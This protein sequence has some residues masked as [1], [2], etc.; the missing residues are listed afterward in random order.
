MMRLFVR[1]RSTKSFGPDDPVV[2][3][4]TPDV[5]MVEWEKV[6]VVAQKTHRRLMAGIVDEKL[7]WTTASSARDIELVRA[8]CGES[9]A[10]P[11]KQAP[12]LHDPNPNKAVEEQWRRF[13]R[14]QKGQID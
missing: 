10:R 4:T 6:F 12:S 8:T 9:A 14:T 11:V 1:C 5:P 13:E 7:G 2:I 3:R